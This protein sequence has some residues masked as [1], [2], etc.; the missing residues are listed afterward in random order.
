[1]SGYAQ[2]PRVI[3]ADQF[4]NPSAKLIYALLDARDMRRTGVVWPSYATLSEESGLTERSIRRALTHL[5]DRGY[6]VIGRTGANQ[7][8][9][10]ALI[11]RVR[12]GKVV[13]DRTPMSG[14]DWSRVPTDRSSV[15]GTDR[16]FKHSEEEEGKQRNHGLSANGNNGHLGTSDRPATASPIKGLPGPSRREAKPATD[17]LL[18]TEQR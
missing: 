5:Q 6:I 2:V 1:V 9:R 14:P 8:N 3:A 18:R 17:P 7:S 12:D 13:T 16:S 15:S 10:Y 11:V 4:L